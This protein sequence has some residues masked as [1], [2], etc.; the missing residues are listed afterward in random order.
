[1]YFDVVLHEDMRPV[2]NGTREET[3]AWLNANRHDP[4][5]SKLQVVDGRTLNF[6]STTEY[7][8]AK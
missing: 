6:M 2:F 5:F 8:N 4:D 1:M 7:L 3:V